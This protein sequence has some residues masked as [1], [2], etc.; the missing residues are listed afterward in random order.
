[1]SR[2]TFGW[3]ACLCLLLMGSACG[4]EPEEGGAAATSQHGLTIHSPADGAEVEMPFSLEFSSHALGMGD[5]F[6][7]HVFFDGNEDD[8]EIA[9]GTSYEIDSLAPGEHTIHVSLRH[10]DHSAAGAEEEVTVMVTGEATGD[11]DGGS[12][13]Y[14]VDY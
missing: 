1:M 9:S 10:G 8:Y 7:V 14:D 4:T 6:H 12:G 11:D 13:R 5:D 2:K 3:F